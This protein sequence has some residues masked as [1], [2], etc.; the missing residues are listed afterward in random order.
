MGMAFCAL[1]ALAGTAFADYQSVVLGDGPIA[2]WRLN[3]TSGATA[4][5][6]GSTGMDNDLTYSGTYALGGT[7]PYSDLDA[8][9]SFTGAGNA[10]N[11]NGQNL[12][13]AD[14]QSI[15]FWVCLTADS[16]SRERL[17]STA[18]NLFSGSTA[19]GVD[20]W[21]TGTVSGGFHLGLT[22][23]GFVNKDFSTVFPGN[24]WTHVAVVQSSDTWRIYVN[25]VLDATTVARQLKIPAHGLALGKNVHT[26]LGNLWMTGAL[27]EVAWYD[28]ALTQSQIQ[29][30]YNAAHCCA[31]A[32]QVAL[33]SYSGDKALTPVQVQLLQGGSV[34]AQQIVSLDSLGDYAARSLT[35]GT[36]DVT[37]SACGWLPQTVAN[38]QITDG[39]ATNI[40]VSLE[41]GDL[42]G[43]AE[44]TTTDASVLLKN[45]GTSG[46]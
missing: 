29:A 41:N 7:S 27:D 14:N 43:D 42:D 30:H 13:Q 31:L 44:V 38:V 9:A 1:L 37:F 32:G 4:V 34:V 46:D 23:I 33:Q 5:N 8:Y 25:G 45:I 26:A 35:P 17:V 20:I 18:D 36:Y 24:T 6:S 40:N 39:T 19:S 22:F 15:E 28:H 2:Y 11:T 10:S 21:A 16:A 12:V 3:E